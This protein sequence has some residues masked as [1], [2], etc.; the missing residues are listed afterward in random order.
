MVPVMR[1][2]AKAFFLVSLMAPSAFAVTGFTRVQSATAT[3]STTVAFGSN[4][5]TGNLLIA[6]LGQRSG[7]TDSGLTVSDTLANTW[8]K[9]SYITG[10]AAQVI[11]W[12][13]SSSSGA[14]T[15]TW[16][17]ANPDQGTVIVE[18]STPASIGIGGLSFISG[19][20]SVTA[21]NLNPLQA[22]TDG[23]LLV[24]FYDEDTGFPVTGNNVTVVQQGTPPG[25]DTYALGEAIGVLSASTSYGFTWSTGHPTNSLGGLLVTANGSG[26][27]GGQ[28]AYTSAQ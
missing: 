5:T 1:N 20:G 2:L 26:S 15:I 23:L 22:P 6:Y 19:L 17:A 7:A 27:G 28:T 12:A 25:S 13:V 8:H 21:M 3:N 10:N 9:A 11:W 14:D 4:V 16:S 24:I 18:Y